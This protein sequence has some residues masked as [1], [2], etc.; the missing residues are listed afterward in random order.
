MT[1][2]PHIIP[3]PRAEAESNAGRRLV[4]RAMWIGLWIWPSFTLLDA[5]MC[6]VAYPDAPFGVFLI[7]RVAVELAFVSTYRASRRGRMKLE[8]LFLF[9]NLCY[10]STALVIALMAVDLGGIR[11]PYMHGISI[12]ALVRAA[13]IPTH[14]RRGLRTY[15]RIAVAFPFVMGVGA[16]LSPVARHE[17]LSTESLIVFAS[18][19]V[20][21]LASA[22]VGLVTGHLVW[23]AQE[24][25][26]RARRVG[27]Y[28]LEAPIGQGGMG[29]VW[30]AWDQSLRRN[31]ALKIMRVGTDT[32]PE[33]VRRFEREAQAAGQLTG[34]HV[35]HIYDFGASDD[36]LFYLA[37]EYLAGMDLG[38]LVEQFGP[39][40]P[41]RV[42]HL[43]MQ[44][45]LAL[46][47]AHA[48]GIIHRD[49][50]PQ[51]LYL[52]RTPEDPDFL[53]LLDF[54]IA[55]LRAED[56]RTQ[57]LTWTGTM[58]GTPAYLAPELW[59][60]EEADERSDVYALGITLHFLLAG[61]T[62]YEDWSV[63]QLQAAHHL[64][65]PPT[66]Q[67][68]CTG[69]LSADLEALLLR[70]LARFPDERFQTMRDL[71]EALSR[72]HD[73]AAWTPADGHAFWQRVER[74][75]SAKR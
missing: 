11:S 17:W 42:V 40:P 9:Q 10:G 55:R 15:I 7:Y 66:L 23:S 45:C 64:A 3:S 49:L 65:E 2:P 1:S 44:A 74:E 32:N 72:L 25:L 75:R 8:R 50:K 38:S 61:V 63:L 60:G 18:N 4:A 28:R 16:V 56:A 6:F 52:T 41:G 30:L 47:E 20:F 26:Y 37:M 27:R 24:Q 13:L 69:P 68:P 59:Q 33:S 35:A 43:G 51:N 73:P 31:V 71:R 46:E 53:K 5:Y 36:G 70:C 58:I 12:V 48:A 62:P 34:P 67:L 19:Y 22:C 21:V 14:W 39:L 57:R 29:E 54:G